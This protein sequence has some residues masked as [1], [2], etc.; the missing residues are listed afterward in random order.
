M[1]TA[2]AM[3]L[4]VARPPK[5]HFPPLRRALFEMLF[6]LFRVQIHFAQQVLRR[7]R[8]MFSGLGCLFF[9]DIL[10]RL[11]DQRLQRFK[12]LRSDFLGVRADY[13]VQLG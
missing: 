6:Q 11:I 2:S 5:R 3:F 4:V 10:E 9:I 7:L 12:Q 1:T 13:R 8:E